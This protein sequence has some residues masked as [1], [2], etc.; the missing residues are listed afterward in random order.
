[1]FHS[2]YLQEKVYN[3]VKTIFG[4]SEKCPQINQ[5]ND[6]KYTLQFIKETLR[7]YTS[8]SVVGRYLKEDVYISTMPWD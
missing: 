2:M 6:M 1:M 5:L 8:A 7:Y 4:D 3:E